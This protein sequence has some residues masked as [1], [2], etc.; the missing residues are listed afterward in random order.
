MPENKSGKSSMD[1]AQYEKSSGGSRGADQ[2]QGVKQQ[3]MQLAQSGDMKA[4]VN[5]LKKAIQMKCM[6]EQE[7]QQLMQKVQ[8]GGK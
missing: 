3:I 2:C 4:L 7:A 1:N 5:G 8:G 6:S